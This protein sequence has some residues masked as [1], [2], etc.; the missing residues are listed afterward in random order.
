MIFLLHGEMGLDLIH[1]NTNP[2]Y[3]IKR[4]FFFKTK[5]GFTNKAY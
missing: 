3:R 5:N 2:I 4:L 1:Y